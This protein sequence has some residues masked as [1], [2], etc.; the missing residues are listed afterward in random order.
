MRV[1]C[2]Y[3]GNYIDDTELECPNC[4]ATNEQLRR[5]ADGI[6]K[7]IEEL[8]TFAAQ[9]NIPLSQMRF[10][11][12]YDMKEPRAYGIYKD[13]S[14]NFI[15]YK[16]KSNGERSIRYK[17]S[18]EAYAVNEIYQKLRTEM[19]EQKL[20]QAEN[21]HRSYQPNRNNTYGANG[22][23]SENNLSRII[24]ICLLIIILILALSEIGSCSSSNSNNHS[25]NNS[26]YNYD[27]S[28]DYDSYYDYVND[29]VNDYDYSYDEWDY[30]WDD[31]DWDYDYDWDSGY[32]DWD[33]DW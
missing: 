8:K 17:G 13:E 18:D 20:Y 23:D 4:G 25:Y 30:D 3:C 24:E 31:N 6:P 1:K 28:H 16:N 5:S 11:L 12:D 29:Y 9:K 26:Y 14:G 27:Y 22:S 10:F 32:S 2:S 19:A 7:T 33:S 21:L 15:V